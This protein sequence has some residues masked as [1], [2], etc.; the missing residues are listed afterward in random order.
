MKENR[1]KGNSLPRASYSC[2][3]MTK[4]P[5]LVVN[6]TAP[7]RTFQRTSLYLRW[8]GATSAPKIGVTEAFDPSPMPKIPLQMRT[9]HHLDEHA[10][11]IAAA[12][13]RQPDTKIAPRRPNTPDCS[14][15]ENQHPKEHFC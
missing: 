15:S 7:R 14:G 4:V 1:K 6:T 2:Q 3:F 10:A 5:L 11:P 8:L 9:T 13:Q 12:K